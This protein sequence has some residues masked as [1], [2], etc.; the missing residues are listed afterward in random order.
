MRRSFSWRLVLL[1]PAALA[2]ACAIVEMRAENKRIEQQV[3]AKE[4]QLADAQQTQAALQAERGRLLA[5]LQ[6]RQ[7][8]IGDMSRRL[9]E[10]Q[11][12]NAATAAATQEQL[13]EKALREQQL[14]DAARQVKALEKDTSLSNEAK[15][16]RLDEVR[17]KLMDTLKV[18]AGSA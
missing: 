13:R 14:G 1:L 4:Q 12:L 17:R 16:R 10:L 9:G 15:Q 3:H 7:M 8:T 11:R 6:T 2:S 18:L 5:D